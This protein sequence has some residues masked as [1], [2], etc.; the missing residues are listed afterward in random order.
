MQ[1][2]LDIEEEHTLT[3]DGAPMLRNHVHNARR[4][5]N[6]WGIGLGKINRS[7][8]DL[9]DY[10]VTMVGARMGRQLAL[11]NPKVKTT[12]N[13]GARRIK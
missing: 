12:R 9:V 6:Q 1:T 3:H 10:A 4:R 7:S 2:A 13:R 8:N 5:P 11:L